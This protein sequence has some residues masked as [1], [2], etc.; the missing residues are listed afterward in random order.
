MWAILPRH[1]SGDGQGLWQPF[2]SDRALHQFI[3]VAGGPIIF[4]GTEIMGRC[5]ARVAA[6]IIGDIAQNHAL[7]TQ[8][9]YIG[10]C[11]ISFSRVTKYRIER[12]RSIT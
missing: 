7:V 2:Q 5:P 6:K 10:R 12:N 4:H 8:L 1:A 11:E 9:G 3:R